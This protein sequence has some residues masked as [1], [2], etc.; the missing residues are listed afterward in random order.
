MAR[1]AR[2]I[3][4]QL[5]EFNR[6]PPFVPYDIKSADGDTFH[7]MHSDFAIVSDNGETLE[8]HESDGHYRVLNV[9]MIVSLEPARPRK[10]AFGAAGKR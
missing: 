9:R 8:V 10:G 6:R 7:V 2:G 3:A 4:E 1:T 5:H